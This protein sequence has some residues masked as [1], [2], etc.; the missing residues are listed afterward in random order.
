MSDPQKAVSKAAEE[1][2]VERGL[3][4]QIVDEGRLARDATARERG[5]DLVKEFVA[6][7]LEGSMTV[8]KDAEAMIN[9]R[10][11]ARSY[12]SRRKVQSLYADLYRRFAFVAAQ[13]ETTADH[14]RALAPG[15][16]VAVTGS[17][18][19][20]CAPLADSP[21]RPGVEAQLTGRQNLLWYKK[22][23]DA[24]RDAEKLHL[25]VEQAIT[26]VEGETAQLRE[27]EA[28]VEHAREAH[29]SAS[30]ALHAAQA[31]MYSA[32]SEVDRLESE[33]SHMRDNRQRLVEAWNK[34]IKE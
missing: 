13:D 3:L 17:L 9:A 14:L 20:A 12:A 28:R 31:E 6:Q 21:D 25:E 10:M 18:K 5:K 19:A 8:A 11:N 22:R 32:K 2:V 26:R 30:D 1:Q 16:V 27:V 34:A 23:M 15:L 29:F 4:D 33:I 7:V 24:R